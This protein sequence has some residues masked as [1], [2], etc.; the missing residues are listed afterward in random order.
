MKNQTINMLLTMSVLLLSGCSATAPSIDS[1]T[2][3]TQAKALVGTCAGFAK[4]AEDSGKGSFV[5]VFK[6]CTDYAI[7]RL[8]EQS[9]LMNVE[10]I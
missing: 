10:S 9:E 5:A 2:P 8:K 7:E 6:E 3:E 4:Q 1:N